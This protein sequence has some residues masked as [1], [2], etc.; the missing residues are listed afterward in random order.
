MDGCIKRE[1][2]KGESVC[3]VELRVCRVWWSGK[4]RADSD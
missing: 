3:G 4:E 1:R 2:E